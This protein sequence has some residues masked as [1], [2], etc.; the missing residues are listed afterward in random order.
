MKEL[1]SQ[2]APGIPRAE[3]EGKEQLPRKNS[4]CRQVNSHVCSESHSRRQRR[5][6]MF[7]QKRVNVSVYAMIA[8]LVESD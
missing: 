8:L 3:A 5:F 1:E 6:Q 2:T 7:R 4:S